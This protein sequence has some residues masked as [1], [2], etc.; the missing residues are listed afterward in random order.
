LWHRLFSY[1]PSYFTSLSTS[2]FPLFTSVSVVL[3]LLFQSSYLVN[4]NS[5]NRTS[6]GESPTFIWWH[7]SYLW[8]KRGNQRKKIRMTKIVGRGKY[9][10]CS[11]ETEAGYEKR[12]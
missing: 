9:K 7:I 8:K 1:L 2:H 6:S 5:H 3:I 4:C 12:K 10:S 11:E